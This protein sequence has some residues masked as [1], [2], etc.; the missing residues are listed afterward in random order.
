MKEFLQQAYALK[1]LDRAGWLRV[2]IEH[3]ES[4]AAHSWGLALLC[5]SLAPKELQKD[6]ILTM[7]LIHDLPEVETGDITPHDGIAKTEKHKREDI[8]AQQLF[9]PALYAIW[10]E[11]QEKLTPE[12]QFIHV[13]DKLDMAIQAKQ[14]NH[15]ADTDEFVNS[16]L[17]TLN[18]E[19]LDPIL[20]R[21][22]KDLLTL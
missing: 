6:K 1:H 13:M 21:Q 8:A 2:G 15:L 18:N 11:C 5:L 14:Y 17:P 3:P 7:A 20:S 9:P 22:I 19:Q 16:A 4:V 10:K 12:S